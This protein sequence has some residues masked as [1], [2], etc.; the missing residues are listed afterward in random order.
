MACKLVRICVIADGDFPHITTQIES[1]ELG[2]GN[3]VRTER[4]STS[5]E[6]IMKPKIRN[7]WR[8]ESYVNFFKRHERPWKWYPMIIKTVWSSKF[9]LTQLLNVRRLCKGREL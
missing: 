5:S 2:V 8:D 4:I 1:L 3:A 7:G 6:A 9:G